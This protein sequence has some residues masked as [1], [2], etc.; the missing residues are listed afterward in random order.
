VRLFVGCELPPEARA[1][2]AA[3]PLPAGLRP[4]PAENLHITLFFLGER[5]DV[6]DCG[7]ALR[8]L[9]AAPIAARTAG[10]GWYGSAL[11]FDVQ[12]PG[13]GLAALHAAGFPGWAPEHRTF[14][15]HITVARRP[16]GERSR[17]PP[18]PGPAPVA[19]AVPAVT[20]FR[21]VP[22]RPYEALERLALG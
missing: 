9:P 16:R 15:P 19:F 18:P 3:A 2:L 13:G 22:G 1:A 21:S 4:V 5:Q 12:D 7:A 8:A 6:E 17:R 14:R 11:A 20:L 10:L